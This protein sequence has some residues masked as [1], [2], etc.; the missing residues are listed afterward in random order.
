MVGD[1]DAPPRARLR[2][3]LVVALVVATVIVVG[4]AGLF[5]V[6]LFG[7]DDEP[8]GAGLEQQVDVAAP[9]TASPVGRAGEGGS[10]PTDDGGSSTGEPGVAAATGPAAT[11]DDDNFGDAPSTTAAAAF[12]TVE[13][14]NE[15]ATPPSDETLP[16]PGT[17][18]AQFPS[19]VTTPAPP[20]T[21]A[22]IPLTE[23]SATTAPALA[24]WTVAARDSDHVGF[25]DGDQVVDVFAVDA[26]DAA[27]ALDW[28]YD[29]AGG[30]VSGLDSAEQV[31]L[32]APSSR[33]LT[34][35]GS[36]FVATDADQLVTRTSSGSV[37]TAARPNGTAVVLAVSRPGRSS[38]EE[39]AADGELLRAILARL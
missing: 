1:G 12:V 22:A 23:L 20:S 29:R 5:A 33:F 36:Q 32:G 31:R 34:V 38:D 16:A 27:A 4:I 9:A 21:Y 7:D 35:L 10:S 15:L 6:A 13:P 8:T 19:L 26:A 18:P 30:D 39:L 28:F 14:V 3:G 25:S 37:V 17:A 24:G 2:P 11:G